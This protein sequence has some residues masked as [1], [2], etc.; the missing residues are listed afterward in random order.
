MENKKKST[1][2]WTED[3]TKKYTTLFNYMTNKYG[4]EKVNEDSF[5]ND[6]K[7]TLMKEVEGNPK[8]GSSAKENY[9]FMILRF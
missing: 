9:Y 6:Y 5:I 8:W 2:V 1:K 7:R 3:N 4:E